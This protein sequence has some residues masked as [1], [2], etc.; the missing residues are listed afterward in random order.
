MP[1]VRGCQKHLD[2]RKIRMPERSGCQKYLDVSNIWM[3]EIFGCQKYPDVRKIQI[4]RKSRCQ[5]YADARNILAPE[6]PLVPE[7]VLV[8]EG[9]REE[10][11]QRKG[12]RSERD[13][14]TGPPK[15]VPKTGLSS[16]HGPLFA[17]SCR[18]DMEDSSLVPAVPARTFCCTTI[19][20]TTTRITTKYNVLATK[21]S[22][23]IS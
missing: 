13:P 8:P 20:S 4:S 14:R 23:V 2:V 19:C 17:T 9:A 5:K 15:L 11:G 1:E 10:K 22:K 6:E 16:S 3:T 21:S 7:K 18:E 12:Q